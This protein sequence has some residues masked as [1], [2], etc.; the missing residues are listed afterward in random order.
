M[1]KRPGQ[2]T[3]IFGI[4]F[5]IILFL[6]GFFM[7]IP[8]QL[9]SMLLLLI[10]AV[11]FLVNLLKIPF[12]WKTIGVKALIPFG[13]SVLFALLLMPVTY[14]GAQAG[15]L[16][17][18][19]QKGQYEEVISLM[20]SGDISISP[21]LKKVEVPPAYRHLAYA[22]IADEEPNGVLTAEFLTGAG[23]PLKHSGYL[24]R[25]DDEPRKWIH[26]SRWPR[27]SKIESK[28]YRISD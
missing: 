12:L 23:F 6:F 4:L 16:R 8:F 21:D 2:P 26:I 5:C 14:I 24:F 10:F 27:V 15:L 28:W 13:Y 9:L 1:A 20:R 19:Y 25:S 3:L 7:N 18:K 22:I 17:F 11:V